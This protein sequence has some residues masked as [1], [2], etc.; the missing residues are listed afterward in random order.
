[1]GAWRRAQSQT[2]LRLLATAW[3]WPARHLER[4]VPPA[5]G[6]PQRA[7]GHQGHQEVQPSGRRRARA[8]LRP[9]GGR[10]RPGLMIVAYT[11]EPGSRSAEAFGLLA[12]SA[13][14]PA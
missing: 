9:P 11:A 8:E 6:R 10:R 4:G 13:A 1:M 5:L 7:P 12:R 3:P 2:S 14:R